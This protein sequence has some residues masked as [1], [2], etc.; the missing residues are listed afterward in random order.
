M[1]TDILD[2]ITTALGDW[3]DAM[4]WSPA[5]FPSLPPAQL[6]TVRQVAHDTGLDG[7]SAWL[8]VSDVRHWGM[9][10]PYHEYVWPPDGGP[11]GRQPDTGWLERLE[12]AYSSEGTGIPVQVWL[13]PST[14]SEQVAAIIAA[15]GFGQGVPFRGILEM[16]ASPPSAPHQGALEEAAP[17]AGRW[18]LPFVVFLLVCVLAQTGNAWRAADRGAIGLAAMWAFF[19]LNGLVLALVNARRWWR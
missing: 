19:G 4:H 13:P 6:D 14:P 2:Q 18:R 11:L 10:S 12:L 3:S 17:K 16:G 1:T 9:A 8:A 15:A 5:V 7:Y